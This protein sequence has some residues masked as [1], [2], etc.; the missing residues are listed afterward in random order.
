[1]S[2]HQG[3]LLHRE[4]DREHDQFA[5]VATEL[6]GV[7]QRHPEYYKEKA[8]EILDKLNRAKD[9]FERGK[10][11]VPQG[12]RVSL[13]GGLQ[14]RNES[15]PHEREANR[16]VED[17]Y[18]SLNKLAGYGPADYYDIEKD[19]LDLAAKHLMINENLGINH[20]STAHW[21][22]GDRLAL[23]ENGRPT[24]IKIKIGENILASFNLGN[25]GTPEDTGNMTFVDLIVVPTQ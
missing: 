7:M 21:I 6:L 2:E 1:M 12:L 4:F 14:T 24:G 19:A 17:L 11:P 10:I 9:D 18:A 3:T 22:K 13:F 15:K 5:V 8:T 23:A 25:F 20:L 16:V